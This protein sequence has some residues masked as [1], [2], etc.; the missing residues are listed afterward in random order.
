MR[1]NSGT[2]GQEERG[3]NPRSSGFFRAQ[4]RT[5]CKRKGLKDLVPFLC[6]DKQA[7]QGKKDY[8]TEKTAENNNKHERIQAQWVHTEELC[9]K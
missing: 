4:N 8:S 3:L 2:G 9:Q 1:L 6:E 5:L 7:L